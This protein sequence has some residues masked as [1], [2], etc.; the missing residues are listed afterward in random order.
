MFLL[1]A[2]VLIVAAVLAGLQTGK[3]VG[4]SVTAPGQVTRLL[5]GPSHPEIRFITRAGEAV[6]YPQGGLVF[7]Y[8]EGQSVTVR[9]DPAAPKQTVTIDSLLSIWAV[10]LF[11]GLLG[12]IFAIAGASIVWS[13]LRSN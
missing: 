3:F 7:G 6:T 9:Y 11:L 2:A 4:R 1:V 13:T 5:A 10:T 8:R 12:A